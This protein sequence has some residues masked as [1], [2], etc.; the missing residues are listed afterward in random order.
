ML[1]ACGI[2]ILAIISLIC[3][4]QIMLYFIINYYSENEKF[5]NKISKWPILLKNSK[6]L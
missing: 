5:I 3:F 1:F 2:L 4:I 6:I